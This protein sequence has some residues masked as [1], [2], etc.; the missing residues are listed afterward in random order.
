M[1]L[2]IIWICSLYVLVSGAKLGEQCTSG[3]TCETLFTS[4]IAGPDGQTS[5]R[6]QADYIAGGDGCKAPIGRLCDESIGM[7]CRAVNAYCVARDDTSTCQC[8]P[9]YEEKEGMCEEKSKMETV[10]IVIIVVLCVAFTVLMCVLA[11]SLLEIRKAKRK[12]AQESYAINHQD[13]VKH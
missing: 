3:D 6:C 13:S 9:D 10:G 12:K 1:F 7:S 8:K 4:C 11:Q 2:R 5:C